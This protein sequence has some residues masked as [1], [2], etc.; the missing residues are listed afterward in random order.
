MITHSHGRRSPQ[1]VYGESSDRKSNLPTQA[2]RVKSGAAATMRPAGDITAE[3][4]E[5]A[6][7]SR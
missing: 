3:T 5:L 1:R 4:P 6:A 7:R 2:A